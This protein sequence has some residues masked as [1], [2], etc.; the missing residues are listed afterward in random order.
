MGCNV[1]APIDPFN[2]GALLTT[3]IMVPSS[4]Y[5]YSIGYLKWTST[6]H[7]PGFLSDSLSTEWI[8]QFDEILQKVQ[9]IL[10][11]PQ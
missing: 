5:D 7:N 1:E 10:D 8:Q 6:C 3:N 4:L 11:K 2:I 9:T